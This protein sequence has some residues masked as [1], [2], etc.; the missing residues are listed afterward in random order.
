MAAGFSLCTAF[1]RGVFAVDCGGTNVC[2]RDRPN[3]GC[4]RDRIRSRTTSIHSRKMK[5]CLPFLLVLCLTFQLSCGGCL[6]SGDFL[7]TDLSS[8]SAFD[9]TSGEDAY[10]DDE[11]P[12]LRGHGCP[13]YPEMCWKHCAKLKRFQATCGG[14]LQMT[15]VC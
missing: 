13:L 8:I 2:M 1:L 6:F 15:C 4:I 9:S 3:P 7:D 11:K 10:D 12:R 5:S 14:V